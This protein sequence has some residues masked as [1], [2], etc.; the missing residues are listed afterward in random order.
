MGLEVKRVL[1]LHKN[2]GL[3]E[4]Q[5][6]NR[7]VD[8]AANSKVDWVMAAI[9]PEYIARFRKWVDRLRSPDT[10]I[11][12]KTGPISEH[13]KDTIKS[14]RDWLDR[15][16]SEHESNGEVDA[17]LSGPSEVGW[18]QPVGHWDLPAPRGLIWSR[19]LA[20]APAF[21]HF[22]PKKGGGTAAEEFQRSW[23][24]AIALQR[25]EMEVRIGEC[26][27]HD[28]GGLTVFFDNSG[29]SEFIETTDGQGWASVIKPDG[30]RV[31]KVSETP[32]PFYRS[33]RIEPYRE[34]SGLCGRGVPKA[35]AVVVSKDDLRSTVHH[36]AARWLAKNRFPV[37]PGA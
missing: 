25:K 2:N 11:N 29:V 4:A 37:E 10:L 15:H 23:Q 22:W 12:L 36:A 17:A 8:I 35:M 5:L 31:L 7:L 1:F 13:E 32:P 33:A 18:G 30:K 20:R 3:T 19:D 6:F 34:I 24:G 21:T 16:S 28:R 14:I 26:T 9:P 27:R